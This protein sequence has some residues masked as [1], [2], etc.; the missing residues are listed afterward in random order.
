MT[1]PIDYEPKRAPTPRG[2][3]WGFWGA[4]AY[5]IVLA[6]AVVLCVFIAMLIRMIENDG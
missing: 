3:D 1:D 4:S 2:L 6:I 5:V